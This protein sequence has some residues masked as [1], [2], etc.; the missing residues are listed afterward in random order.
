MR[1]LVLLPRA[2]DAVRVEFAIP[3]SGFVFGFAVGRWWTIVAA[4]PFGAY[5]ALTN[6]FEGDAGTIIALML[7]SLLAC[8]IGSGVA[9]RRLRRRRAR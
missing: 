5:I 4:A 8:A 7:A 3:L 1:L 9:L 2:A 6:P